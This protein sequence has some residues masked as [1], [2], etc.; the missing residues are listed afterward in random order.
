M[1]TFLGLIKHFFLKKAGTFYQI[2]YFN[3]VF[4]KI[5]QVKLYHYFHSI[6]RRKN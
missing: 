1:T 3:K 2:K 5:T 6:L 4:E